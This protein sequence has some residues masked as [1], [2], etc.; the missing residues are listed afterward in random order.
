MML[1]DSTFYIVH[2]RDIRYTKNEEDG[3]DDGAKGIL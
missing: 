1:H 2:A 3:R